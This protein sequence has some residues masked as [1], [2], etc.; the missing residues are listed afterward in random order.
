MMR[1]HGKGT[2]KAACDSRAPR[3]SEQPSTL[4]FVAV[5]AP[6]SRRCGRM[7]MAAEPLETG[8]V[9]CAARCRPNVRFRPIADTRLR[10]CL[11]PGL[12]VLRPPAAQ[13]EPPKEQFTHGE[14]CL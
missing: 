2:E 13:S 5:Y 9:V 10:F 7:A 14:P 8:V 4:S 11:M 6:L 1:P 3:F 12:R